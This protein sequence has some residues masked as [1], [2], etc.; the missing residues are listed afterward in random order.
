M[1]W[2]HATCF[3]AVL[4]C[5]ATEIHGVLEGSGLKETNLP[6]AFKLFEAYF[7][8]A[9]I[10]DDNNDNILDCVVIE[11][12]ALDPDA[13]T[14]IYN[15]TLK[16]Q[17]DEPG[18]NVLFYA[19]AEATPGV[20]TYYTSEDPT[21]KESLYLYADYDNCVIYKFEFHGNQCSLWVQIELKDS[22]PQYCIDQFVADCG[23]VVPLYSRD[24]CF[25][26][27]GDY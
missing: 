9:A 11:R 23:A 7:S 13:R 25:D 26:G 1:K 20:I 14:A 2:L 15:W 21:I 19:H 24:L 5:T 17:D 18:N 16:S 3:L 8:A 6:D 12:I 4:L 10:F 22:V 27:E